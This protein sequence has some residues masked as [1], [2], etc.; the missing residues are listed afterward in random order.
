MS[1]DRA[2]AILHKHQAE[3]QSLGVERWSLFGSTTRGEASESSD[4]DIS[5]ELVELAG[6]FATLRLLEEVRAHLSRIL[7]APVDIVPVPT[8]AGA[9]KDA[10]DKDGCRAF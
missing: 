8:E 1:R 2:L 6:G 4:I 3:L 7:D 9:L 5:V 10:L